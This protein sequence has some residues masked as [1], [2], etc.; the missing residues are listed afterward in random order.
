[1]LQAIELTL[2]EADFQH[3]LVPFGGFHLGAA[4]HHVGNIH[5]LFG[6]NAEGVELGIH[7]AAIVHVNGGKL[8]G[9]SAN[10]KKVAPMAINSASA[11]AS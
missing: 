1:M 11:S 9:Q 2:A 7:Q 4:I 8:R 6:R 3:I 5:S 10:F